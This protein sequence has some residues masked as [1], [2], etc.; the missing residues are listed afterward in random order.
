MKEVDVFLRGLL[1]RYEKRVLVSRTSGVAPVAKRQ[2]I[3]KVLLAR[4]ADLKKLLDRRSE[5]RSVR[6]A[7]W[8]CSWKNDDD[9]A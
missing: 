8:K 2:L 9:P 1:M 3:H 6:Y 7:T 5:T 4:S